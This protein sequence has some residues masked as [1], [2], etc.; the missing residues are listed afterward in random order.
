MFGLWT[1]MCY[2]LYVLPICTNVDLILLKFAAKKIPK[3]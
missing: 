3:E 1:I 2:G